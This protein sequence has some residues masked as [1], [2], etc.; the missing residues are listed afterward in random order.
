MS[1]Q[2]P[3]FIV[4][5]AARYAIGRQTYITGMMQ[6]YLRAQWPTLSDRTKRIIKRDIREA[7]KLPR[8][9]GHD[10]IDAPGW[11]ALL[12]LDGTDD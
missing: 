6:D 1:D 12:E 3:D 9:L 5:S 8:G 2:T 10:T 7:A 11:L 4:V